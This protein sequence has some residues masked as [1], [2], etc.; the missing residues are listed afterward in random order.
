MQP[1]LLQGCMNGL[2]K[3]IEASRQLQ[4]AAVVGAPVT[5]GGK[6]YNCA[7]VLQQGEVL[8]IVPKSSLP[9]YGEF[10]EQRHFN[11]APADA[12]IY[13]D[14]LR[15]IG[16]DNTL[17]G[18]K[19]LFQ[20]Q[21]LPDFTFA[22]EICEDL[23]APLPPFHPSCYSRRHCYLQFIGQQRINR[24]SRLPPPA[25]NRTICPPVMRLCLRQRRLR[26]IHHRCG[27]FRA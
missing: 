21:Q 2:Q 6:L 7:V 11:T 15:P 10:Y 20:C 4:S 22:V 23:W 19:Q 25:G 27:V 1:V 5:H 14:A 26:R 8:G 17:F 16:Q 3:L 13:S 24:Q 12:T 18:S 9:T